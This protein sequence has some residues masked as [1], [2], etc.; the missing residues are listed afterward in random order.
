M[1]REKKKERSKGD[2]K[3]AYQDTDLVD[4]KVNHVRS[5][6]KQKEIG[7]KRETEEELEEEGDK[8]EADKEKEE[9]RKER[10]KE[11]K[12]ELMSSLL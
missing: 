4:S 3:A 11:K 1:K 12:N 6:C 2:F 8:G 7:K 9:R 10:E 5:T